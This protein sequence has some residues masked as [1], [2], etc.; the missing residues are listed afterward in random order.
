[1]TA[2]NRQSSFSPNHD[3]GNFWPLSSEGSAPSRNRDK[4]AV[5][6]GFADRFPRSVCALSPIGTDTLSASLAIDHPG[7]WRASPPS[8]SKRFLPTAADVGVTPLTMTPAVTPFLIIARD[9]AAHDFNK[10]VHERCRHAGETDCVQ[11]IKTVQETMDDVVGDTNVAH[12]INDR[13]Q[14]VCESHHRHVI[15]P[16]SFSIFS[17][18]EAIAA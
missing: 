1:M 7:G 5:R 11:S 9:R 4:A 18:A 15:L 10:F 13:R 16:S 8:A 12:R 2:A 17:H 14:N 6:T 3:K